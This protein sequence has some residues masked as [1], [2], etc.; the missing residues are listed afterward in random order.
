MKPNVKAGFDE[1]LRRLD[2]FDAQ[3]EQRFT[4][5]ETVREQHASTM[6]GR[7]TNMEQCGTSTNLKQRDASTEIRL[8]K[9]ET[10]CSG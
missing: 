7:F 10:F 2:A 9:L 8:G 1:I 4:E 6:E 5:S 3:W